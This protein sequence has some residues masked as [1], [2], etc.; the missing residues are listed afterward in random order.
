MFSREK[1]SLVICVFWWRIE[2]AAPQLGRPFPIS[3]TLAE[4]AVL[5]PNGPHCP[6]QGPTVAVVPRYLTHHSHLQE[7]WV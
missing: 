5:I 7:A 1:W 3:L 6:G 2:R 4:I